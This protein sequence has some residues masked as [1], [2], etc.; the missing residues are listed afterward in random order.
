M[1]RL[2][3]AA[4]EETTAL[5]CDIADVEEFA[6]KVA[7]MYKPKNGF[8]DQFEKEGGVKTFIS[9]TLATLKMWK[10]TKLAEMW[11]MWLKEL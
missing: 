3:S 9:V 11:E 7:S 4:E 1:E 10:N 5:A 8:Y 6:V 2:N